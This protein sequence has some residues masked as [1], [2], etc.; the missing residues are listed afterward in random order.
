[1]SPISASDA[2]PVLLNLD[3]LVSPDSGARL[4]LAGSNLVAT[5]ESFPLRDGI[6][7]LLPRDI[8]NQQ[9]KDHER[10]GW[11][12]VFEER[13]WVASADGILNL[14][15]TAGDP[16]LAKA[17]RAFQMGLA[18]LGP[19]EGKRGLD[20]ACGMGWATAQFAR[21]GARMIA[22]DFNDTRYNGLAA[23][24]LLRERGLQLD[25]ICCDSEALPIASGSLDFAFVCSAVHHFTRPGVALREIN[26]VL[27]AGGIFLNICESFR[28]GFGDE[29]RE[30]EHEDLVDFRAAGINEQAYHQKEYEAYF[31]AAGFTVETLL[32]DWDRPLPERP[33]AEWMNA[34]LAEVARSHPRPAMRFLAKALPVAPLWNLLRWRRLQYTVA[35][36]IFVC[37]RPT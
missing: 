18:V 10:E 8:A 17:K 13:D 23:A 31:T 12:Q 16:Y 33:V 5:G 14:L 22:A 2:A 19:L 4:D 27:K 20:L 3:V 11:K 9:V 35:D 1:M 29:I 37:R 36:R 15:E 6:A 24:I 26:R 25:A 34:N 7:Y 32:L 30:A 21:R 28:T